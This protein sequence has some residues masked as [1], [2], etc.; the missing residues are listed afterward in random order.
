MGSEVDADRQSLADQNLSE[1]TE[2]TN[3]CVLIMYTNLNIMKMH[4]LS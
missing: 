3:M 2:L 1:L 4:F